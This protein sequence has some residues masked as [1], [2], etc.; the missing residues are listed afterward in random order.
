[1]G[2]ITVLY[3]RPCKMRASSVATDPFHD[4][5]EWDKDFNGQYRNGRFCGTYSRA[6]KN[7]GWNLNMEL[8][9]MY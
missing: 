1:M 8:K 4:F 5:R 9:Q 6:G 3:P 2:G 7:P